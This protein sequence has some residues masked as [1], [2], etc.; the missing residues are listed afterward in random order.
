MNPLMKTSKKLNEMP[1]QTKIIAAAVVLA[2]VSAVVLFKGGSASTVATTANAATES[3]AKPALVVNLTSPESRMVARKLTAHGALAAWEEASIGAEVGGLR[4]ADVRARV[5]DQVRRGQ[6]LAVFAGETTAAENAQ[7]R[8][9]LAEAEAAYQDAHANAERARSI[10]ATGALSAQQSAQYLTA[11]ASAQAR[12]QSAKANL[13]VQDLRV[14]H[15]A[16]VASDDGA[17]SYRAPVASVGSVIGQGSELFRLVRQNRI[18]WRAEV[19]AA[20][21]TRLKIGEKV[22][23]MA[24]G[25]AP[26]SGTV[27]AISPTIDPQTRNAIVYVDIPASVSAGRNPAYK[28]GMFAEGSFALGDVA[29]LTLP[30]DAVVVRD[31]YSY[32]FQVGKNGRAA[33]TKVQ[34]G[35]RIS[36][37][38]K[39]SIEILSGISAQTR[40]VAQ[41][42]GF[43]NDGDLVKVVA[44]VAASQG[45]KP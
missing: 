34:T 9:A 33:M 27:R 43:L 28:A 30:A 38:G 39:D 17:I 2:L 20:E 13:T 16:V 32:V 6:V 5:G 4:L 15:T 18:E 25:A 35:Q 40:V 14:K 45:G 19:T 11:E 41:G 29:G 1:S 24:A 26:V 31:G 42:A 36:A 37:N 10:Q 3:A 7:A 22:S 12:L 21:L 44:A 23:L 8:A